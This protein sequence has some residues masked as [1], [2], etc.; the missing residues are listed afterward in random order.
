VLFI[1]GLAALMQILIANRSGLWVDEIFSLAIATGHSL[2]HPAAVAD[3]T[4]GDFVEPA[5]PVLAEEFRRYLKHDNPPASLVRVVRAVFLSD[6]NPP[7]Y[8]ALL[9]AWTLALGTSDISLR[10]FSIACSLACLP[11]LVGVARRTGGS[12]AVFPACILFALSPLGIY[13]STEG[14]MYS[15]LWLCVLGTMWASLVLQERGGGIGSYTLWIMSSVAGFL[16]HYFFV[17]PWLAIIV[18]LLLRPGK[19]ARLHLAACLLVSVILILP[20]YVRLPESIVAWRITKDWI[21][22]QPRGFDRLVASR[23]IVLQFF[24]GRSYLWMHNPKSDSAALIFFGIIAVAM[25]WR[26]R[27]Q[28]FCGKRVLLWLVFAATCAGP[29]AF[30]LIQHTY[31][32]AVPRYAIAALP[33]AYLLTA[34]GL[35]CLS[36][37]I[38]LVMLVLIALAWAPNVVSIYRNESRN[39][40]AIREISHTVCANSSPSDL[41]LVHSIPSGVLG[42]ARYANGPAA[43]ASWVGQLGT[44]RVPESIRKL[45]A[46][47]TRVLFV[48]VHVVGAPAPEEDWLRANAVVF[49]Q[50]RLGSGRITD[51]RPVNS[52]AF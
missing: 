35:V 3:P 28:I 10:L 2:E 37:R 31:V 9:Y 18:Y 36:R 1:F 47:R 22:W 16:T 30:D 41:I 20:W 21:K 24:W 6:T 38:R 29:L 12:G 33:V 27:I 43:L 42:I 8:Y 49:R 44:H 46:G 32:V 14:R 40:Q 5:Q 26:L 45:T 15:L 4:R 17:F 13:Y 51:F 19:L 34:V 39:R 48:S 11:L 23:D 7:L 50:T 52:D 25:A